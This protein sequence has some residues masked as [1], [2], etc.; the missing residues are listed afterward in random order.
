MLQELDIDEL[1]RNR[2]RRLL[3]R[4][5]DVEAARSALIQ[6]GHTAEIIQDGTL[7]LKDESSIE[8]PDD[9]ASLLVK[10]GT[11]PT[12]LMVEEEELEHYFLRL[13]GMDGGP[14]HE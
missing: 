13:V 11:P 9:I 5:R 1:E 10:A 6:A 2:R 8:R 3:L 14:H 12:H 7:E 4:T